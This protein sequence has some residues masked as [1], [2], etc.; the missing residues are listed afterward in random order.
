MSVASLQISVQDTIAAIGAEMPTLPPSLTTPASAALQA[1]QALDVAITNELNPPPPHPHNILDG[2]V[3][4]VPMVKRGPL[5]D[6]VSGLAVSQ[7]PGL[8][9][10]WEMPD[11]SWPWPTK[12]L[13]LNCAG[14][15][16][17]LYLRGM[18]DPWFT[19]GDNEGFSYLQVLQ[20][21]PGTMTRTCDTNNG[22]PFTLYEN[23]G[24]MGHITTTLYDANNKAI[25]VTPW[26]LPSG[27]VAEIVVVQPGVSGGATIYSSASFNPNN[28]VSSWPRADA[29]HQWMQG[30][31]SVPGAA[32]HEIELTGTTNQSGAHVMPYMGRAALM[33]AA[34]RAWMPDEV[35]A[36][37]ADPLG[38]LLVG[39]GAQ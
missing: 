6:Q 21:A 35:A 5:V 36:I 27:W 31:A 15:A 9:P 16:G 4:L 33:C 8:A 20:A 29:Y 38:A 17:I 11:V 39:I 7:A 26:A 1:N 2:M 24:G 19:D 30:A 23:I 32:I 34:K 10:W 22:A 3:F 18:T 37:L 28:V 13:C 12:G 14:A 25:V